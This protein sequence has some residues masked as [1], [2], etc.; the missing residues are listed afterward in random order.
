MP[1]LIPQPLRS[2]PAPFDHPDWIFELKYDGFRAVAHVEN[3]R[4]Q[5]IS[6]NGAT[7]AS[8]SNLAADIATSLGSRNAVL[9][10]E[11]VCLDSK[12]HSQFRD[13]L[14]HRGE[15]CF[16]CFDVLECDRKDFRLNALIERKA[17]LRRILSS[18]PKHSR[19]RYL[20]HVDERGIA[21]FN[22]IC[23][24]DLEGIVAKLKHGHYVAGK[25]QSTWYK[26]R[27]RADRRIGQIE[28][29]ARVQRH[30]GIIGWSLKSAKRGQLWHAS[31]VS[32]CKSGDT[33][34]PC[35]G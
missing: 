5:L 18:V 4:C 28:S 32:D 15:P 35:F 27:N 31:L 19:V 14:F 24:R 16:F 3:G 2:K 6:R 26:I 20:G 22:L 17:E 13:L 1:H 11:I 30:L 12:G 34:S 25:E 7:F 9:D 23:Q 29:T 33:G 10:G 8:F 21:L